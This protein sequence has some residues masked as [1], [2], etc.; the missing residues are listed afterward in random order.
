LNEANSV[1]ESS[2]PVGRLGGRGTGPSRLARGEARFA[3][4]MISPSLLVLALVST[5]PLLVLVGMSFFTI[6]LTQVWKN[7]FAGLGNY[8]RMVQD[9][10]FWGSL[11]ITGVYTVTTVTLQIVIGLALA[12]ALSGSFPGRNLLRTVIL[13]PM[14]LAPVVVGLAWRT[15]L[16]TPRYGLIDYLAQALGVGSKSWLGDP[17]LALGS[18]IAIHTWQWTP[19]AF[20]VFTAALAALPLEPY[21]AA[22][23]D[24]ANAW[25][26]FRYITLPLIRPAIVIIVI[27]RSMIALRAFAAIFAATGG[28]P[29]TATEILNLYAYRTS[30]SA[31]SLGYGA[32]LATTLLIVTVV[33]SVTFFR[34]RQGVR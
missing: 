17:Q 12:L 30:F 26:M 33:L 8:A 29:G 2:M 15:L 14:M 22:R 11:A 13:M 7:G 1:A 21:E 4:L 3:W 32:A 5:I 23:L 9:H 27:I 16:L 20:L 10:R 28:G 34:V 24:R 18:V 6:E 25:Q 19:F 31:F